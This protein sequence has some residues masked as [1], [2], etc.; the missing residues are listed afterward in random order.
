MSKYFTNKTFEQKV[1]FI[2]LTTMMPTV[3]LLMVLKYLGVI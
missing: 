3:G 1:W 2:L